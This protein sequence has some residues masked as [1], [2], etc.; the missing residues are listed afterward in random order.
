MADENRLS[1]LRAAAGALPSESMHVRK[2]RE[3]QAR[4]RDD[5]RANRTRQP[6]ETFTVGLPPGVKS[7]IVLHCRRRDILI[8]DFALKW[9]EHG[10]EQEGGE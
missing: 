8:K 3:K 10:I 9:L 4:M 6:I 7:R 1:A 2:T 5:G